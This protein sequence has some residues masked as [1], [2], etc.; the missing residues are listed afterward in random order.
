MS[1]QTVIPEPL[2]IAAAGRVCLP[3]AE[4]AHHINRKPQTMRRWAFQ[5]SGPI[6][7]VRQGVRLGWRV[8]DLARLLNGDV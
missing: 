2:L 7:P 1:I 3:T 8:T 6:K 4:A 5:D